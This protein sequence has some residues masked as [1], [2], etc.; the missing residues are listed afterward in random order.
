M[1][2]AGIRGLE[3]QRYMTVSLLLLH[4]GQGSPNE[5]Y[6]SGAVSRERLY[7][8]ALGRLLFPILLSVTVTPVAHIATLPMITWCCN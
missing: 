8:R 2:S 4:T 1:A 7:G 3:S 6:E 5:Q